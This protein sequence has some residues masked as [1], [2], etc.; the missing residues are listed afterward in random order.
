MQPTRLLASSLALGL[1]L[2]AGP[3]S[4]QQFYGTNFDTIAVD[5]P[6]EQLAVPGLTFSSNPSGVWLVQ[7]VGFI[8]LTGRALVQPETPGTLDII[9]PPSRSVLLTFAMDAPPGLS[10]L[11]VQAF[12][13]ESVVAQVTERTS[14]GETYGE[15]VVVLSSATSFRR[16]RI[17]ASPASTLMAI[18]NLFI[19]DT[20]ACVAPTQAPAIRTLASTPVIAGRPFTLEWDPVFDLATGGSYV[21]ETAFSSSFS[22]VDTYSTTGTSAVIPT[23]ASTAGRTLYVRVRAVQACG[24]AGPN[25]TPAAFSLTAAPATFVTTVSSVPLTTSAG[26]ATSGSARFRNVGGAAGTLS[27]SVA[28]GF[29]LDRTSL[30]L[31]PNE[32]GV[33]GVSA[34]GALVASAGS[35]KS[36]LS[37]TSGDLK[38]TVPVTLTV[39][40]SATTDRTG[41]RVA[42]SLATVTF[43]APAG[44]NPAPRTI[45]LA[46]GPITG[47]GPVYLVPSVGPGGA[48]LDL[49]GD[50]ARPI[51]SPGTV[52]LTLAVN[53]SARSAEDGVAPYRTLVKVKADGANDAEDVAV[54]EVIDL[55][56]GTVVA[57]TDRA[58]L[59]GRVPSAVRGWSPSRQALAAQ[60]PPGGT[61]FIVPSAVKASG[62]AGALFSSDG[63]LKNQGSTPV[64]ATFYFTPDGKDG[65]TDPSVLKS[66]RTVPAGTTFRL[67]EL[68]PSVFGVADTSGQVEIRSPGTSSLTL[69][70]TVESVT[71]GDAR[72]RYGTEIPTVSYGSG[73][74]KDDGELVIPGIDEDDANR[75]NLIL[76][77]TTGS[78]ATVQ[79]TVTNGTGQQL[80]AR[81]FTVPAYGKIQVN[82][83]VKAI[84]GDAATLTGGWAGL[85][86]TA[87]AGRVVPVA[88]V[89]D[90]KS[91]SFSAIK[92]R[93]P[94]ITTTI[95]GRSEPLAVAAG[96]SLVVPSAARLTGAFNTRYTTSL[97]MVNGTATNALLTLTYNYVDV[98][99]GGK[100]KSV[101]K[102]VTLPPRGALSKSLGKDVVADLFGITVP[103]YGWMKLDGD[104]A[105]IVA[106][107]GISAL[108]DSNDASRGVKTSQVDGVLTSS[109]DVMG[110]QELERRFA[111][112]EKSVQRRTNVIFVEVTG[113]PCNLVLALNSPTGSPLAQRQVTVQGSQYLQINDVFGSG[114]NGL[115]LGDGPFQNAEVT[116]RVVSGDGRVIGLATVIDNVSNNPEVFVLKPAGTPTPS[117]GF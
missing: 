42:P 87:G 83:L 17:S 101:T 46:V 99:D 37:A 50:Y 81:P 70:T 93:A 16:V 25:S 33:V 65:L 62:G 109:P 94:G 95:S 68:L 77:E 18:D 35:V 11:V 27:L 12:D 38:L 91:N 24:A 57:G 76:T 84:V 89:I 96:A 3:V 19:Y 30:S 39:T 13:G 67:S 79:I 85:T 73:V 31:A 15:G 49:S 110:K 43:V 60:P 56:P 36:T 10:S 8:A 21:V 88:T 22:S 116:A 20:A 114:P 104:V 111:G 69:R 117:L 40:G 100:A 44:Q 78:S 32:E 92:G 113:Q 41:T 107:S 7:D 75:V 61:S 1:L 72:S 58:P 26:S 115:N 80:G 86:V 29:Q 28:G 74:G 2:A 102:N 106:L 64:A 23:T 82:G 112:A 4:A 5:V 108:V 55:E 47:S 51:S 66:T 9:C 105:R 97:S 59:Q 71:A 48:W 14:V 52:S 34:S 63:W 103:S 54:I 6:A 90:N 45:T 98:E 53:R